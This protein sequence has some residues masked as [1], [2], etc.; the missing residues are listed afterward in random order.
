MEFNYA[1]HLDLEWQSLQHRYL[2]S[3]SFQHQNNATLTFEEAL[4]K[5]FY[6]END[7]EQEANYTDKELCEKCLAESLTVLTTRSTCPRPSQINFLLTVAK[8]T[9][10]DEICYI[11]LNANNVLPGTICVA[12]SGDALSETK[13]LIFGM[14]DSFLE[15]PS[16]I[17]GVLDMKHWTYCYNLILENQHKD[18]KLSIVGYQFLTKLLGK[19]MSLNKNYCY[20]IVQIL[21]GPLLH[22]A[23]VIEVQE[24]RVNVSS[25]NIQALQ[26]SIRCLVKVLER[27]LQEYNEEVLN[28]V[29]SLRVDLASDTVSKVT[30][31]KSISLILDRIAMVLSFFKLSDVFDG[32]KSITE[33]PL[34]ISGFLRILETEIDKGQFD[35]T[36][37]LYYYGLKY[38]TVVA[39]RLPKCLLKGK[40]VDIEIELTSLQL[41]P[42]IMISE[43]FGN[44]LL[45]KS[46]DSD[47]VRKTHVTKVLQNVSSDTIKVVSKLTPCLP[48]LP[49]E[50]F[51]TAVRNIMRA[52]HLYSK[53][54][55]GMVFEGLIFSLQ[56]TIDF[57]KN[58]C[59]HEYLNEI[60]MDS[61][62]LEL[63][64][65]ILLFIESFNLGWA[66]SVK[67][68]E[69][70]QL[71]YTG[72][73]VYQ[74]SKKV[75]V[76]GSNI[77][78]EV[79]ARRL[80]PSMSL[81]IDCAE[82]LNQLGP[83]LYQHCFTTEWEIRKASLAVACTIADSANKSF[84]S[85]KHLLLDISFPQLAS[86]M[87]LNDENQEVRANAFKCLQQFI[88]WEEVEE[89]LPRNYFLN[90]ALPTLMSNV[91]PSLKREVIKLIRIAY[92]QD[93][94]LNDTVLAEVY[95][96]LEQIAL[97]ESDSGVQLETIEFWTSVVKKH[98]ALQGWLDM[99]FPSVTFSKRII[100][101]TNPEVR[102]RIFKVLS[103]LSS[104]GCLNV[105][106]QMLRKPNVSNEVEDFNNKLAVRLNNLFREYDLTPESIL[107]IEE[108][109][110]WPSSSHSSSY[111]SI[112]SPNTDHILQEIIDDTVMKLIPDDLQFVQDEDL[113]PL[114]DAK[115]NRK[116]P[117]QP[118]QLESQITGFI[119]PADFVSLI[120]KKIE[121]LG[122]TTEGLEKYLETSEPKADCDQYNIIDY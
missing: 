10:R 88:M 3:F 99:K 40:K 77:L 108:Y 42:L 22:T 78:Q 8:Y 76:K 9:S 23:R 27:L 121:L 20:E 17:K 51:I 25:L 97:I 101:M 24:Q 49:L 34:A 58:C 44:P 74:W 120:Y 87:A 103:Q 29:M 71:L 28:C 12:K 85:F 117:S 4:R 46:I 61:F 105:L 6:P 39:E 115:Y 50:A 93:G 112:P 35:V 18:E 13:I 59:D 15:H 30:M 83:V 47:L 79:I 81:L 36:F 118:L 55:L 62:L 75:L 113:Y 38:F 100:C 116:H 43:K 21:A 16:G 96:H 41:G 86:T 31:D 56:D 52:R 26:P 91:Q 37:D 68:L 94:G 48:H 84:P 114:M 11:N 106:A 122:R 53:E 54:N 111:S 64:N 60:G 109:S 63:F 98:L 110:T 57:V 19:S 65:A 69:I 66:D 80:S 1:D 33:D 82:D 102:K 90:K 104:I 92:N 70:I 14:L 2:K 95:K 89:I 72:C 7:I 45:I 32:I 5:I 107:F 67:I 73:T 119:S